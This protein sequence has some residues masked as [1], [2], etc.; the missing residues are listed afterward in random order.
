VSPV[1]PDHGGLPRGH[2]RPLTGS[3]T[4]EE[5]LRGANEAKTTKLRRNEL[6]RRARSQ[7]LEL[8]H[9]TYGYA[10]IDHTRTPF[11]G[12]NDLTLDDVETRLPPP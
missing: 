1:H 3:R 11:D 8:R 2:A 6:T 10:L 7:G 4:V 9:S 5:D 12:R